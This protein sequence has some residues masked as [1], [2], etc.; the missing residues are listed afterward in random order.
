MVDIA[1]KKEI[2]KKNKTVL[3]TGASGGIGRATSKAFAS[4]GYNV[5][6][7]YF[8]NEQSALSLL[9]EIKKDRRSNGGTVEIFKANIANHDETLEM[10]NQVKKRYGHIDVLINN[11]GISQQKLFCDITEK[12]WREMIDTNL[13]G[14][15]FASKAVLPDMI[16]KKEGCIINISSIWGETGGSCEV[17]YSAAKAGIIGLTKALAKEVAPSGIRVNCISPGVISTPMNNSFDSEAM[18]MLIDETPLSR[19][20]TPEDV[21]KAALFLSSN[22]A[23]FITG[24]VLG[25]NG[26]ILI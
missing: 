19:L 17:H 9:D 3:I 14:V 10:V 11:A 7:H 20:G 15:F 24:Q 6:A 8:K 13:S 23:G 22:D 4:K 2:S 25:V 1:S 5:A 18:E 16:S 26:G 21:A 12:D